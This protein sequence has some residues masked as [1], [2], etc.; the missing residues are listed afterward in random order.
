M[1]RERSE[2][3]IGY[4]SFAAAMLMIGGLMGFLTGISAL[5]KDEFFVVTN[6]WVFTFDTTAWGWIHLLVGIVLFCSGLLILSGNLLGRIIGIIVAGISMV[7]NFMWMP[8]YPGWSIVL[9]ALNV[10]VIWALSLHGKDMAE[11]H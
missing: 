7:A 1:Q 10:A 5:T 4:A 11:R 2:W 9:I 3:A 8:Y 6:K